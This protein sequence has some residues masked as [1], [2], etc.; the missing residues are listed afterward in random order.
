MNKLLGNQIEVGDFIFAHK[1][2]N[3]EL[4]NLFNII[5]NNIRNNLIFIALI[6][7]FYQEHLKK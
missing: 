5:S 3:R 7:N 6:I 2:G 1:K 4:Y